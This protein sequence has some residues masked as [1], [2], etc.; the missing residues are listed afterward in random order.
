MARRRVSK[1][2]GSSNNSQM[3]VI[4]TLAA[5]VIILIGVV[6]FSKSDGDD[7]PKGSSEIPIDILT[8]NASQ[9]SHNHYSLIGTVIDRFPRGSAEMVSF[10]YTNSANREII[11]PI[12]IPAEARNGLNINRKQSYKI[13]FKVEDLSPSQ[14]GICVATSVAPR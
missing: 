4:Y 3:V 1:K 8:T 12:C 10:L 11:I 6:M 13:D 5:I 7:S 14:R 9:L 2:K